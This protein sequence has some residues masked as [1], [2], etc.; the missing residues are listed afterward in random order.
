MPDRSARSVKP[1]TPPRRPPLVDRWRFAVLV[2]VLALTGVSRATGAP[3]SGP[4]EDRAHALDGARQAE[5]QAIGQQWRAYEERT[6]VRVSAVVVRSKPGAAALDADALA[7]EPDR[8]GRAG[9]AVLLVDAGT[10]T[11]A[12]GASTD[13]AARLSADARSAILD[14]RVLPHLRVGDVTGAVIAGGEELRD[15]IANGPA[16]LFAS[17]PDRISWFE[18]HRDRLFV[19]FVAG[20]VVLLVLALLINIAEWL[21][22]LPRE[23][24][25][26]W[27]VLDW[28]TAIAASIRISSER[29]SS[30][31][32]SSSRGGGFG[33]GGGT[34]A[35]GGASGDW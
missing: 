3:E 24:K 7:D 2:L 4:I 16:D 27:K 30:G 9:G 33:G 12:V 11:A 21:G 8:R 5:V 20:I 1:E 17:A 35:G 14:K 15:V 10:V 19:D 23:R 26:V 34:S 25:G 22:W 32:S 29:G 18:A 31:P 28:I 13:V 6:G